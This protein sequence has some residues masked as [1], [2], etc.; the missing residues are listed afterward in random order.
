MIFQAIISVLTLL[1]TP[2]KMILEIRPSIPHHNLW[3]FWLD[4]IAWR[5][6]ADFS[7]LVKDGVVSG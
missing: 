5:P 3:S 4:N 7:S 2:Q 1:G 6:D